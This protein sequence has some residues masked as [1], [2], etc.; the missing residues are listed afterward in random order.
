MGGKVFRRRLTHSAVATIVAL[1]LCTN[2][3]KYN[4]SLV[5]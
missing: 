1:K 2:V 4:L 5:C 3:K